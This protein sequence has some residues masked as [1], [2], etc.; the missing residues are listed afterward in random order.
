MTKENHLSHL[1]R[2]TVY[3]RLAQK[4]S[5]ISISAIDESL[6]ILVQIAENAS[7][8]SLPSLQAIKDRISDQFEKPQDIQCEY[9]PFFMAVNE[10]ERLR[11]LIDATDAIEA[12]QKWAPG[13]SN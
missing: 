4:Y 6:D 7:L 11:R 2:T 8:Q 9:R 12:A 1:D 10:K 13:L 3:D 5:G